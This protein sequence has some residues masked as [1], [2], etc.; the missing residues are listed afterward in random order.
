MSFDDFKRNFTK[1]EICNLTPDALCDD[2]L[3]RWT[4]SI[5]EG[6]WVKGYTFWTNPQYRLKLCEED[7]DPDVAEVLCT[8]VVALMQKNRRKERRMGVNFHTIGFAIYE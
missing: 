3:H 2:K 8:F 1:L 4:V 7:D 6:R 5:N